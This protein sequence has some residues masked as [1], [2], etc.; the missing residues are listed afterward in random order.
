MGKTKGL[1]FEDVHNRCN[2]L[3]QAAKESLKRHKTDLSLCRF[4]INTM[5]VI[6]RRQGIRLHPDIKRTICKRCCLLLL[7]G[8]SA[9]CRVKKKHQKLVIFTCLGCGTMKRFIY[10]KDKLP[11]IDDPSAWLDFIIDGEQVRQPQTPQEGK[12]GDKK[13]NKDVKDMKS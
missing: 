7:P 4:Y 12:R 3:Y 9:I 8:I 13:A 2:F 5:T 11:T 10:N 6:A 1:P